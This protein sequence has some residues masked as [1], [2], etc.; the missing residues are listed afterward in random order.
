MIWDRDPPEPTALRRAVRRAYRADETACVRG[1]IAKAGA[2][3]N[4]GGREL[5]P[6]GE[7]EEAQNVIDRILERSAGRDA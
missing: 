3:L 2:F 5:A 4:S 1:L 7:T 6:H